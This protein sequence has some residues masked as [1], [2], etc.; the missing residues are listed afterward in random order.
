MDKISIKEY[1]Q[2]Y[3]GNSKYNLYRKI[4]NGKGK[5]VAEDVK[6]GEVFPIT[7]EQARGFEPIRPTPIENLTR[8]L[9]RMLLP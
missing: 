8:E 1:E 9:G 3:S 2:V 7:Y 4:E 6:T 5:W